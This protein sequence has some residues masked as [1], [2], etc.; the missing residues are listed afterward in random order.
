MRRIYKIYE[1][2]DDALSKAIEDASVYNVFKYGIDVKDCAVSPV[3]GGV[4]IIRGN[5]NNM[6]RNNQMIYSIEKGKFLTPYPILGIKSSEKCGDDEVL[7]VEQSDAWNNVRYNLLTKNG[8]AHE[9]GWFNKLEKIHCDKPY[10]VAF[11]YDHGIKV[12]DVDGEMIIEKKDGWFQNLD[13]GIILYD[14]NRKVGGT[15]YDRDFEIVAEGIERSDKINYSYF[16]SSINFDEKIVELYR[17]D[18]VGGTK[19][20]IYDT[21]LNIIV[22]GISSCADFSIP[23]SVYRGRRKGYIIG[24]GLNRKYNILGRDGNV[25]IGENDGMGWIDDVEEFEGSTSY[26]MV[27]RNEGKVNL[28]STKFFNLVSDMWFDDI[29]DLT[30]ELGPIIRSQCVVGCK[31]GNK[32]NI[33]CADPTAKTYGSMML[34]DPVDNIFV[35]DGFVYVEKDGSYGLLWEKTIIDNVYPGNVF[36]LGD[37][38]DEIYAIVFKDDKT[39]IISKYHTKTFSEKFLDGKKIDR[40]YLTDY[41]YGL[42]CVDGKYTYIDADTFS[43]VFYDNGKIRWFD[44]ADEAEPTKQ[45]FECKV[46]ENGRKKTLYI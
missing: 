34:K 40:V 36:K 20:N 44:E 12:F 9:G 38:S 32:A 25:A 42:I 3:L 35:Y 2:A 14:G 26:C 16:D 31:S 39:D 15:L 18:F 37:I 5:Q 21:S 4:A 23:S 28:F 43:P 6:S 24:T 22:E 46:V 33:I 30:M 41:N 1:N 11:T 8:L 27:V 45:G 19:M 17:V 29:A 13:N 10:F 7:I